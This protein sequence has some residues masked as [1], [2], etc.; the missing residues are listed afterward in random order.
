LQ[1]FASASAVREQRGTPMTL[2]EQTH[3]EEQLQ[4]LRE[5]MDELQFSSAWSKGHIMTMEQAIARALEE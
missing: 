1:L 2:D 5:K 4:G 3:F